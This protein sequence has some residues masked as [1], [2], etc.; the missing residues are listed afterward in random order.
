MTRIGTKQ[1]WIMIVG[2]LMAA[3][4]SHAAPIDGIEHADP[5][6]A[7]LDEVSYARDTQLSVEGLWDGK[8]V[9]NSFKGSFKNGRAEGYGELMGVIE[10]SQSSNPLYRDLQSLDPMIKGQASAI[11]ERIRVNAKF[12]GE[13]EDAAVREALGTRLVP[14]TYRGEFVSGVASGQGEL[15]S[16]ERRLTGTFYKWLPEG[17]VVHHAGGLPVLAESFAKGRPTDGPIL[18]NQYPFGIAEASRRFV[19]RRDAGHVTGTWYA[20]PWTLTTQ[21]F[22]KSGHG[23]EVRM[24]DASGTHYDCIYPPVEAYRDIDQLLN[25]ARGDVIGAAQS[26]DKTFIRPPSSCRSTTVH[27]WVY[28]YDVKGAGLLDAQPAPPYGCKSPAGISGEVSLV[29]DGQFLCTLPATTT[30]VK[31]YRWGNKIGRA[32]EKA[33]R[34][35]RDLVVVVIVDPIDAVGREASKAVCD[36]VHKE[37]G[38][39][40]HVHGSVEKT[41]D[42]PGSNEDRNNRRKEDLDRF[43]VDREILLKDSSA[44]LKDQGEAAAYK[45]DEC[46]RSC[47]GAVQDFSMESLNEIQSILTSGF[48]Q[49]LKQRRIASYTG[50]GG[51]FFALFAGDFPFPAPQLDTA[52][53]LNAMAEVANNSKFMPK[54]DTRW[55]RFVGG[56]GAAMDAVNFALDYRTLLRVQNRIAWEMATLK[57]GEVVHVSI[58]ISP[59]GEISLIRLHAPDSDVIST[60]GTRSFRTTLVGVTSPQVLME[61]LKGA[62]AERSNREHQDKISEELQRILLNAQ[63]K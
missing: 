41:Y 8:I 37:P 44:A 39:N 15:I 19:G 5:T 17:M 1:V 25:A 48:E 20:L 54:V 2:A 31:E 50:K 3:S 51:D 59:S 62:A 45:M 42:L 7:G 63:L 10:F 9:L 21:E 33:V 30:T 6:F 61:K 36:V 32:L 52:A 60:E 57:G 24:T 38:V 55:E 12:L 26:A 22:T 14:L 13:D 35:V 53:I 40:C 47:E 49:D 23:Q 43:L 29:G 18:L 27:G 4:A 11:V 34:D 58:G 46:A 56:F 16:A 28:T